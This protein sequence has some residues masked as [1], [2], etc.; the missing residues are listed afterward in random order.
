MSQE[1]AF[2]NM[3]DVVNDVLGVSATFIP[4]VGDSVTLNIHYDQRVAEIPDGFQ[5]RVTAYMREI[6]FL[7]SDIGRIPDSGEQFKIDSNYY[8]VEY[9][10]AHEQSGRFVKAVVRL[11][12]K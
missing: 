1:A 9:I 7:Y 10:S 5:G 2:D 12:N 3:A 6:E 8:T 11:D 4:T